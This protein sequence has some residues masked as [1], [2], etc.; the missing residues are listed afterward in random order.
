VSRR[1]KKRR[2]P[3]PKGSL[4]LRHVDKMTPGERSQLARW[5]EEIARRLYY[6]E[7]S[8]VNQWASPIR[9]TTTFTIHEEPR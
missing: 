1:K 8:D 3:L 6:G 5:L 2:D 7:E 4:V 9:F